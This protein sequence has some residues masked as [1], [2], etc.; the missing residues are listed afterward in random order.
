MV[1][2]IKICHL[3]ALHTEDCCPSSLE[4]YSFWMYNFILSLVFS[5]PFGNKYL[6]IYYV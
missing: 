4:L 5:L 6:K 3:E 2:L 1:L